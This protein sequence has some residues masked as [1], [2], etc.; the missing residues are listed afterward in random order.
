[1]QN[2][3]SFFCDHCKRETHFVPIHRAMMITGVSRST[4]YYWLEK[5]WVHWLKL[6]SSRRIICEESL[7]RSQCTPETGKRLEKAAAA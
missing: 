2:I 3:S 5:E 1:M 4:I 7:K 6:P